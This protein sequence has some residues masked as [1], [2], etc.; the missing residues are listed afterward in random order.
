LHFQIAAGEQLVSDGSRKRSL[1]SAGIA[2]Q[3]E[4]LAEQQRD[5]DR[6]FQLLAR[7]VAAT[8]SQ[9]RLNRAGSSGSPLG[10]PTPR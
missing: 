7:D 6:G 3:Q 4:R 8:F 10:V 5:I 9:L 1:A 2:G